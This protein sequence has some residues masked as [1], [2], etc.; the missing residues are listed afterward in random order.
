MAHPCHDEIRA[1]TGLA[2]LSDE[3]AQRFADSVK[4]G[5]A[6]L[7]REQGLSDHD[8][9]IQAAKEAADQH[10][11]AAQ[12]EKRNALQNLVKRAARRQFYESAPD[13]VTGLEAKLV[14]VNRVFA[15]S[16]LSVDAQGRAMA[17]D[18][19]GGMTAELDRAG[20]FKATRGG[21]LDRAIAQE[22]FELSKGED[23]KPGVSKSKEALAAAKIINRYQ[24]LA[25]ENLNRAGA[26]VGEY[27]GYI[28][29]QSHNPDLIRRAGFDAWRA[30]I[31]PALDERTF[32]GVA[33]GDREGFLKRAYN[34][35]ITGVHLSDRGGA[36]DWQDYAF[37]GPGSLAKRVSQS[38]SLHFR[39]S[40][41]WMDYNEKFGTGS[42]M[43]TIVRTLHRSANA[44]ALMREYG[45]NPRA[46]FETDIR[47]LMEA[48]RDSDPEAVIKLGKAQRMLSN[49]MDELDGTASTPVNALGAR[50]G[51]GVRAVQSLAKLGG[52]VISSLSD[53]ATKARELQYQGVNALASYGD[54]LTSIVRGRGHGPEQQA[55]MDL[56]R[57]GH[58]GMLGNIAS[59]FDG[60]DTL[61]GI[62]SKIQSTYF[63]WSLLTQWTDA[64]KAGLQYILARH[65][66][67]QLDRDW[68]ALDAETRR[69]L[70]PYGFDAAKW[71]AL[72]SA[73]D[74]AQVDGRAFL[75]P[76]AALRIADPAFDE[77]AR[78]DLA[79]A[80]HAYYADR[81]DYGVTT[82]TARERAIL[83]QGTRPGTVPGELLRTA[84]QFK[85]FST[86]FITKVIG[87]D[88][89][90][91]TTA[92]EKVAGLGQLIVASTLLGYGAMTLKD[93]MAGKT[94]RDPTRPSTWLQSTLQGGG[95]GIAG[96]F[97][98]GNFSR[99]GNSALGTIAGPTFGQI[100]NV[101]DLWNRLKS[102]DPVAAP[103]FQWLV[104][105]TPNVFYAKA[106]LQVLLYGRI[107][108]YLNPGFM[109]RQQRQLEKQTGQ[110]QWLQPAGVQ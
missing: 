81:A 88:L 46:A 43:E 11:I 98:L 28:T 82:P 67:S 103:A 80:L 93:L 101:F 84:T 25:R 58:E 65:L 4:A 109:R 30:V 68:P 95:L 47:D 83:R 75:T 13:L 77:N 105:N 19:L 56:L 7:I 49:R 32:D 10:A 48:K 62:L 92:G 34:G 14:G 21:K 26:S 100:D 9:L 20:L 17:A 85:S 107:A 6:R 70:T 45:T 31:E 59:R 86:A 61:P 79:L 52:A 69:G 12:I 8:A 73:P 54:G 55:V 97:I 16:R 91:D 39:T 104:N 42:L 50:I 2:D 106:A 60:T 110:R 37:T 74:H 36:S 96:D 53:I 102:G 3:E 33:E 1:A 29:R 23:S 51:A 18:Y 64:Q 57:A 99:F 44:T 41:S 87:R 108:E 78:H 90:G 38:R 66:G 63:R 15:G 27:A 89:H 94:A 76:D 71:E 40:D 24:T 5:R 22:L 35:L 72:R